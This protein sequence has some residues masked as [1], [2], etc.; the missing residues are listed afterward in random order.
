MKIP[1]RLAA[2]ALLIAGF[3]GLGLLA[4]SPG[5]SA[6]PTTNPTAAS[7][8]GPGT[9]NTPSFKF[10][11]AA[12]QVAAQIAVQGSLLAADPGAA[13]QHIAAEAYTIAG[14]LRSLSA[15]QALSVDQLTQGLR[16]FGGP[17]ADPQYVA[18]AT[19]VG[20]VY[21]T[22]YPDLSKSANAQATL[23]YLNALATG[24]E[25]GAAPYLPPTTG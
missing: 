17:N 18:L 21:A 5:C 7:P 16:Q 12:A 11:P 22:I 2:C 13:R 19:L 8:G 1:S 4:F 14:A 3:L 10:T 6:P 25:A 20:G 24:V 15:G 23:N 9:G